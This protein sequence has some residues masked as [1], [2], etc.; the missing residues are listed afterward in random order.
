MTEFS[1]LQ[2]EANM[3]TERPAGAGLDLPDWLEALEEEVEL[4]INRQEGLEID[5][6]SLLTISR[7]AVP[8]DDLE[9]QLSSARRQGRRLPYMQ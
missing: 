7:Q 5:S 1:L 2:K 8:L 6:D 4:V 3:L 9:Q